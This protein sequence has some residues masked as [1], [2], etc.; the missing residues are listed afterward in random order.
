[1]NGKEV[2]K[3]AKPKIAVRP[4]CDYL[5]AVSDGVDLCELGAGRGGAHAC[6]PDSCPEIEIETALRCLDPEEALV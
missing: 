6:E 1:M 2:M 4:K 5:I 3:M